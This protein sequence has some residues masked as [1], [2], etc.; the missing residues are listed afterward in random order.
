MPA[1]LITSALEAE[2]P[3]LQDLDVDFLLTG[4]GKLH[5]AFALTKLLAVQHYD[6]VINIGSAASAKHRVGSIL[7]CTTFEQLGFSLGSLEKMFPNVY[8]ILSTEKT[9]RQKLAVPPY[10]CGTADQFLEEVPQTIC[11]VYDMESYAQALVCDNLGVSFFAIKLVS[12]NFNG[13][14]WLENHSRKAHLADCLKS[15]LAKI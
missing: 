2:L 4:I 14:Q 12:D 7:V 15:C 3:E 13:N 11:D 5:T 1:I 6:L 8:P 9:L 10:S